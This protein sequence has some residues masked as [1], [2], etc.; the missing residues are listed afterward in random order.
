MKITAH[1]TT[2][3]FRKYGFY[4]EP[5]IKTFVFCWGLKRLMISYQP[6]SQYK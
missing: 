6:T 2:T 5:D 4:L 3:I 1:K